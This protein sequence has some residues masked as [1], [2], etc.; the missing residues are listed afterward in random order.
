MAPTWSGD[1]RLLAYAADGIWVR[2]LATGAARRLADEGEP[3]AWSH[4]SRWLLARAED[5]APILVDVAAGS[6][7]LLPLDAV[8]DAGWLP[9]AP[10]AWLTGPGLRLLTA[11]DPPM[12][13][14][15]LEASVPTYA[16][17]AAPGDM[18]L[19]MADRGAGVRK[20][21]VDL[22]ADTLTVVADGPLLDL[23]RPSDFAWAPDGRNAA[24]ATDVGLYLLDPGSGG[25]VPL[26]PGAAR[27]PQW[28]AVS[29]PAD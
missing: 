26:V 25:V 20:H 3:L 15:L 19:F 10:V 2:D 18:L 17:H 16:G 23:S 27:M 9:D 22:A 1:G 6:S 11:D 8:A 7:M 5:G 12:L 29:H 28:S 24:A 21:S 4:D 14:T 13:T